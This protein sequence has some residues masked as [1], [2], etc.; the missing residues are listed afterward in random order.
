MVSVATVTVLSASLVMAVLRNGGAASSC[1]QPGLWCTS[2]EMARRC[3]VSVSEIGGGAVVSEGS[4]QVERGTG[5]IADQT[6]RTGRRR[7]E[8]SLLWIC[9]QRRGWLSKIVHGGF[10][11]PFHLRSNGVMWTHYVRTFVRNES[12]QVV[13]DK[14]LDP[15]RAIFS[16]HKISLNFTVLLLLH[17]GWT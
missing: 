15:R 5:R 16:R 9:V 11:A 14:R 13:G 3:Q 6:V 4:L 7:S 17:D 12:R 10:F 8:V 1:D 2:G